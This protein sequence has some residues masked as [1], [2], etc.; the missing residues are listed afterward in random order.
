V[1]DVGAERLQGLDD[2]EV[3]LPLMGPTEDRHAIL[4]PAQEVHVLRLH[5]LEIDENVRQFHS[6]LSRRCTDF[7]QYPQRIARAFPHNG[8][9]YRAPQ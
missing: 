5:I 7:V 1:L 2:V 4:L 3:H 8:V 9:K 6:N